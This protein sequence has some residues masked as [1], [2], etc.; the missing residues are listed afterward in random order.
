MLG[1]T[2]PRLRADGRRGKPRLDRADGVGHSRGR[3]PRAEAHAVGIAGGRIEPAH[4]LA[5]L[6]APAVPGL[7]TGRTVDPGLAVTRA[8]L[9]GP[10]GATRTSTVAVQSASGPLDGKVGLGDDDGQQRE[11][12]ERGEGSHG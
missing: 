3:V 8:A 1:L 6:R 9:G 12:N 2:A 10:L 4:S 11:Q 5:A 7:G